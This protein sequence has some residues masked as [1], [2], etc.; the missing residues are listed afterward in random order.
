MDPTSHGA[1]SLRGASGYLVHDMVHDMDKACAGPL[2]AWREATARSDRALALA[3]VGRH[4]EADADMAEALAVTP[5]SAWAH[6]RRARLH[7]MRGD[8]AGMGTA[9][10]RALETSEPPLT[11]PQR[12]LAEALLRLG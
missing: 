12:A 2:E 5:N 10:Q 6:L 11:G 3:Q 4:E 1:L 7:L 9:V 8:V